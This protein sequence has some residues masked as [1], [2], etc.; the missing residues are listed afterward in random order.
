M[1][2]Q[3]T[4]AMLD[5]L[6]AACEERPVLLL[7]EDLHW[8]DALT[9]KLCEAAL[10]ELKD[11]PLMVLALARPEVDALFPRLWSGAAQVMRLRPLGKKAGERLVQQVLGKEVA[12]ETVARI[13]AQ[14][15]G[16]ALYLEELIR[17]A[18]EGRGDEAPATVLAMLQARIDRLPAG[19]RRVLRAASVFGET[20]W[21][22]GIRALLGGFKTEQDLEGWLS[23]LT[24]E[25]TLEQR[26]ESRFPDE[27]EY[28]F[29]HALM[30]DAAYDLL[31]EDDRALS[32]RLAGQYL[33]ARGEP[34]ALVLAEHFLSGKETARA[35]RYFIRAAEQSWEADDPIAV[36]ASAERG[37]GCGA[38]G[39]QRGAL[40]SLQVSVYAWLERYT[41][42]VVRGV[43]A[44]DLLAPGSSS[45]CRTAGWVF[46]AAF[47]GQEVSLLAPLASRFLGVEPAVSA[48]AAYVWAASVFACM[49]GGAGQKDSS[50]VFL[51]RAREVGVGIARGEGAW[52]FLR[53]AEANDHDMFEEAP[54]SYMRANAE[55][56]EARRAAGDKRFQ[57]VLGACYGKALHELGDRAGAEAEM[58]EN[59][60]LAEQVK[61]DLPLAFARTY[62][63]R[64][65]A[66]TAPLDQLDEPLRL[67]KEVIAAKTMLLTG[68]AYGA[69][70]EIK[71]RQGD[72]VGAEE[73]ARVACEAAR[74]FPPYSWDVIA[75]RIRILLDLG[76]TAE[77]LEIGEEAVQHMEQLG[78]EGCGELALRLALAE[79]RHAAG[80]VDAARALLAD[81]IACLKKRLADIPEPAAR[82]RYLTNVPTNARLVLLA[83]EW[84][85]LLVHTS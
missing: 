85:G 67:A 71:R 66:G 50:R 44:L 41:D 51:E 77:A 61:E 3:I 54:W 8:G 40:L 79:A 37:L 24:Q 64:L 65:L 30:R 62:L 76:R 58:R 73:E 2:D 17:A 56:Q 16:N 20:S 1:N 14:S 31:T 47:F 22:G 69:L 42:V 74:P 21:L 36:L 72:L 57:I 5:F 27:R 12:P 4:Q 48:R 19:A 59:L 49:L 45:W 35:I 83:K 13:V 29:R 9:V 25:E 15:E 43:E 81:A 6:R 52:V 7:L 55:G 84:L 11:C 38:Q 28:R 75:L 78:L 33:E 68:V 53:A 80:Q 82:E 23:R 34:Q 26:R 10:R 32:H 46:M 70:A 63:A 60:T 18:A 39:E